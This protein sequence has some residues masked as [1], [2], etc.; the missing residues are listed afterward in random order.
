MDVIEDPSFNELYDR[1]E[2]LATEQDKI[3]K[4]GENLSSETSNANIYL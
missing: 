4:I 2:E 3:G 1:F